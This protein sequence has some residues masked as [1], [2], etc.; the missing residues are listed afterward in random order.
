MEAVNGV[1][2]GERGAPPPPS[3][4][5]GCYLLIVVGE[6]HSAEHKDIILQRVAKED[7]KCLKI[8]TPKAKI[9]DFGDQIQKLE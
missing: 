6:P 5:T 2:E 9:I 7:L 3:P 4:L 8:N 1:S